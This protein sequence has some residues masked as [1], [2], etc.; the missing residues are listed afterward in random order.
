MYERYFISWTADDVGVDS[1]KN[2]FSNFTRNIQSMLFL[3][4]IVGS[5]STTVYEAVF[6][7]ELTREQEEAMY[8]G[9][10]IDA[11]ID[12]SADLR[13]VS[14][15]E[16]IISTPLRRDLS[17]SRT[18]SPMRRNVSAV[19]EPGALAPPATQITPGQPLRPETARLN[20]DILDQEDAPAKQTSRLSRLFEAQRL[21]ASLSDTTVGAL[22]P[23]PASPV[24]PEETFE[25][26]RRLE[27]ILVQI[28]ELPVLRLKEEIKDVQVCAYC[29]GACSKFVNAVTH[30]QERQGHIESLLQVL[31]RG[32]RNE[33]G[34]HHSRHSNTL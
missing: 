25:S 30:V 19:R 6:E 8:A 32:M 5:R 24:V 21:V 1:P 18:R 28:R 3:E 34:Q 9:A 27:S 26:L 7:T 23:L 4:A 15:M 29:V 20:V 10:G 12:G 14:S 22:N 31:T 11:Y 2:S 13:S 17:R 33:S 16:G